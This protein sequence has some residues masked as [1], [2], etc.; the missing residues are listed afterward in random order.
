[1]LHADAVK[2][3]IAIIIIKKLFCRA[4]SFIIYFEIDFIL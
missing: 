4:V 3:D 1:M 2:A